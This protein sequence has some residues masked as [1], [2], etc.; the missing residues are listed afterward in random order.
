MSSTNIAIA[1]CNIILTIL[2]SLVGYNQP[3][4][5]Q[6]TKTFGNDLVFVKTLKLESKKYILLRNFHEQQIFQLKTTI[7]HANKRDS[8]F[9]IQKYCFICSV[10]QQNPQG[11]KISLSFVQ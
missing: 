9:Q 7:N 10:Q 1:I 2:Q 4:T 5:T 11:C 3:N 8:I 6:S